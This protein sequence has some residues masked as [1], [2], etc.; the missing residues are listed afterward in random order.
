MSINYT[1]A[2]IESDSTQSHTIYLAEDNYVYSPHDQPYP[3]NLKS[4]ISILGAGRDQTILDGNFQMT[5]GSA[6]N[7]E[8]HYIIKDLS[9]INGYNFHHSGIINPGGISI[10][11]NTNLLIE[12]VIFENNFSSALRTTQVGG[13]TAFSPDSS[14]LHLKNVKIINNNG[15]FSTRLI[16]A[17][18][19]LTTKYVETL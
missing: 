8:K 11:E 16:P 7:N 4:Y 1:L 13:E 9:I 6:Y 5:V 3:L 17:S 15:T 18:A 2:L 14:S 19:L 12:N 10:V